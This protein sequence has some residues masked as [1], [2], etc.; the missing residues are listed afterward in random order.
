M[1]KVITLRVAAGS[2][3][4]WAK[5]SAPNRSER[6]NRARMKCNCMS[7]VFGVVADSS[8]GKHSGGAG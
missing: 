8:S 7:G 4:F 5:R 2:V 1:L 6:A 3:F